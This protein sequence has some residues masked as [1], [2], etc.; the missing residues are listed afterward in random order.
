MD[1]DEK[2]EVKSIFNLIKDENSKN[3]SVNEAEYIL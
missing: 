2:F 3:N 1:I